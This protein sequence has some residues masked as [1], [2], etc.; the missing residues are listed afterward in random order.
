MTPEEKSKEKSLVSKTMFLPKEEMLEVIQRGQR[1][2]IG[3]PCDFSKVEYRVPLTPQA[4]DLLVS[5]GHEIVIETNA[6]KSASLDKTDSSSRA[7][8][9]TRDPPSIPTLPSSERGFRKT[10]SRSFSRSPEGVGPGKRVT[11]AGTGTSFSMSRSVVTSFERQAL[12]TDAG[13][14]VHGMPSFSTMVTKRCSAPLSQPKPSKRLKRHS[15]GWLRLP[16]SRPRFAA[17]P[18]VI[19]QLRTWYRL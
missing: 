5:Y 4:V 2:K 18:C 11:P 1:I 13:F 14:P 7:A 6:G 16:D 15:A 12:R 17:I 19:R 10:G 3:I 9:S 8:S